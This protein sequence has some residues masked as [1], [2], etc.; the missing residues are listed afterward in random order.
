MLRVCCVLSCDAKFF[1]Q[2]I[3]AVHSIRRFAPQIGGA[4]I[5]I[6]MVA[7]DPTPAQRARLTEL[8]I[9]V[10]DD[11]ARLPVY[12]N[13]PRHGY[14]CTCR[15]YLPSLF[16]GFDAYLWVDS[17]IRFARR[18]GLLYWL[19]ALARPD[20][21]A[22]AC[23]ENEASYI[24]INDPSKA[25]LWGR[26]RRRRMQRVWSGE[27]LEMASYYLPYN[28]GL[29]GARAESRF[30]PTYARNF[31]A[32][33]ARGY[34]HWADQD[35]MNISLLE[36]GSWIRAP[37]VMNWICSLAQPVRAADGTWRDPGAPERIISVLHLTNSLAQITVNGEAMTFYE[38]YRRAGIDT[39]AALLA[40]A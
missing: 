21:A 37:G 4:E 9:L 20:A 38:Y 32:A 25:L 15:P 34:D 14:S 23:Q 8:G 28:G 19:N 6:G 22:V 39:E 33:I 24:V 30:W 5:T 26:D 2:A 35:G 16:P 12:D 40:A 11:F 10:F 1:D 18:E 31:E 27:L 7:I 13:M 36:C 3:L 17:D 29:Y